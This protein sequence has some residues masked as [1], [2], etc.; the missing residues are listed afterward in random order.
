MSTPECYTVDGRLRLVSDHFRFD[1]SR[2]LVGGARA[3]RL[4][5]ANHNPGWLLSGVSK[6][7]RRMRVL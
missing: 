7:D 5:A 1:G 6:P 3:R 4:R 2:D